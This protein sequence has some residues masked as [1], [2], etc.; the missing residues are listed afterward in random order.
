MTVVVRSLTE[1]E[2]V[3]LKALISIVRI[4]SHPKEEIKV[5]VNVPASVYSIPL[6][7]KT[8]PGQ[9]SICELLFAVTNSSIVT[10]VV[11]VLQS[12]NHQELN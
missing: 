3:Q 7:S 1:V 5:S 4:E 2:P 9:S 11:S 12:D 8:S 6:N 10:V